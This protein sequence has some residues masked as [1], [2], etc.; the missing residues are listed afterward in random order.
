MMTTTV[1]FPLAQACPAPASGGGVLMIGYLVFLFGL[2]YFMIFRPQRL[3]M[4][5]HEELLQSVRVGDRIMTTGGI[6]ATI[7]KIKEKT[8]LLQI[9]EKTKIE[10]NR[11]NIALIIREDND[12]NEDKLKKQD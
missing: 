5:K 10:L 8:L 2:M 9:A 3:K 7:V 4:K 6:F 1:L 11:N 12:N